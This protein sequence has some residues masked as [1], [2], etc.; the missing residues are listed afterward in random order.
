MLVQGSQVGG[1]ASGRVMSNAENTKLLL[2]SGIVPKS[3]Q[4]PSSDALVPVNPG[5]ANDL[6]NQH[7]N[8]VTSQPV[9]VLNPS[10]VPSSHRVQSGSSGSGDSS[11]SGLMNG[12]FGFDDISSV[13]SAY[14]GLEEKI[15]K[16]NRDFQQQSADRAMAFNAAE[17]EKN[18]NW[19]E[20]QNQANREFQQTSADKAMAFS[21]SEADK[22]R[23]WQEQMSNTAYQRS[24]ADAIEAGINPMLIAQQGGASTP[25]AISGNGFAAS[26]SVGSGSSASGSAASGSK[27]DIDYSA[28]ASYITAMINKS[29]QMYS[30]NVNAAVGLLGSLIR[31]A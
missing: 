19:Q 16:D 4:I 27:A 29:S 6:W 23:A 8:N 2:Q 15:A 31:L 30:S 12:T 20:Q 7:V 25:S 17:A 1:N 3:G 13:L 11:A 28:V 22:N 18:R 24:V 21:A 14:F 10:G 26:G 9:D 5:S